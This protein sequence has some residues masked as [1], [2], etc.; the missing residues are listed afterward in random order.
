[1]LDSYRFIVEQKQWKIRLV[2]VTM[3]PGFQGA[4]PSA[5]VLQYNSLIMVGAAFSARRPQ[6]VSCRADL[7]RPLPF[8]RTTWSNP[9]M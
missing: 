2:E 5:R 4:E 7:R 8:A 9:V 1:M 6:G 3:L